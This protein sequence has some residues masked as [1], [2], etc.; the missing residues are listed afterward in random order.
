MTRIC[1]QSHLHHV[2]ANN[3]LPESLFALFYF[4]NLGL[5]TGMEC[6]TG[7][8]RQKRREGDLPTHDP[9]LHTSD[10]IVDV[11]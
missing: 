4:I 6:K 9:D 3:L 8:Q 1:N 5:C 7:T 10:G 11:Q 2:K